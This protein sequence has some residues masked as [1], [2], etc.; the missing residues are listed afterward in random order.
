MTTLTKM[1][2]PAV[3]G[4]LAIVG[5]ASG[6]IIDNSSSSGCANLQAS[7]AIEDTTGGGLLCEDVPANA[8]RMYVNGAYTQFRCNAYV[9]TSPGLQPGT[10]SVKLTLVN[11][12]GQEVSDTSVPNGPM[13]ITVPS[14]G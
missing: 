9:G 5:T 8:V 7:W 4:L 6:C 13:S 10:Y 12:A 1:L 2:K 11:A 14:C 3:L